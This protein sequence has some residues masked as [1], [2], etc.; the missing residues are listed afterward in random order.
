[1]TQTRPGDSLREKS[2]TLINGML[3]RKSASGIKKKCITTEEGQ[4]ALAEING[5]TCRHHAAP[6]SLVAKAFR[7]GFYY[8]TTMTDGK[9]IVRICKG[10]KYYA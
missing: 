10:C 3:Y 2:F 7:Q 5:G 9:R 4:Q 6:R 8:P 1:M